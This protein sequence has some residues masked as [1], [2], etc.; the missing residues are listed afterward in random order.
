MYILCI[1]RGSDSPCTVISSSS[2]E[3]E[4]G[5]LDEEFPMLKPIE[6]ASAAD[7][8]SSPLVP[9]L[10][11]VA[12][13]SV[14]LKLKEEPAIQIKSEPKDKVKAVSDT[15]LTQKKLTMSDKHENGKLPPN[16]SAL[17][18]PFQNANLNQDISVTLT[19]SANAADDIGGVLS[20]IAELLKIAVPPSYEVGSRSPSP[21]QGKINSK[22]KCF[23]KSLMI[24]TMW[25]GKNYEMIHI[26]ILTDSLLLFAV[27]ALSFVI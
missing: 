4:F 2:P 26:S 25:R 21:E 11:P 6:P 17:T 5:D 18:R 9:I 22:R 3:H 12:V 7:D 1:F 23:R 19:L 8:R 20:Q 24:S 10:Q 15:D 14:P 13:K 27:L 16:L